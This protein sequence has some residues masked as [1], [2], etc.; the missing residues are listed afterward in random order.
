M[1]HTIVLQLAEVGCALQSA[2]GQ[3]RPGLESGAVS[4]CL[5]QAFRKDC[6]MDELLLKPVFIQQTFIEQLQ[7]RNPTSALGQRLLQSLSLRSLQS[8]QVDRHADISWGRQTL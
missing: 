2:E 7:C 3:G 1:D 4:T 5:A 6:L 8:S